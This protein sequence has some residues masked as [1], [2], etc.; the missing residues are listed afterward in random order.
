MGSPD[1]LCNLDKDPPLDVKDFDRCFHLLLK[2]IAAGLKLMAKTSTKRKLGGLVNRLMP[3]H[4]R[5]Y[6]KEKELRVEDLISLRNNHDLLETLYWAAPPDSRPPL[7]SIRMLVDLEN[8][9][10]KACNVAV[11]AWSN[12]LRFQLHTNEGAESL[13]PFMGWF[14]DLATKTLHQ[15]NA[16]RNEAQKLFRIAQASGNV[17]GIEGNAPSAMQLLTKGMKYISTRLVSILI[18]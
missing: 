2:V 1:F 18:L 11:R 16:A 9:H 13:A 6:P 12:L 17:A 14:D 10:Q 7:E 3:N 4:R 5:H 15:H 8:S